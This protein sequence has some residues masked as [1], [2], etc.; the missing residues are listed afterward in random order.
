[1]N[2]PGARLLEQRQAEDGLGFL[3]LDV[4]VFGEKPLRGGILKD[5]GLPSSQYITEHPVRDLAGSERGPRLPDHQAVRVQSRLRVHPEAVPGRHE[6]Q[7][8]VRASMVHH[9]RHQRFDELDWL[10]LPRERL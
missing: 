6:Q 5:H 4:G 9:E 1:V 10:D 8:P 7:P 3:R 2:T